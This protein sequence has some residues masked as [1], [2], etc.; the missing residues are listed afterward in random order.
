MHSR[1]A[2]TIVKVLTGIATSP[3][4]AVL[5]PRVSGQRRDLWKIP[6]LFGDVRVKS[7]LL[8]LGFQFSPQP[9]QTQRCDLEICQNSRDIPWKIF[10]GCW[11]SCHL[12]CLNVINV[13]PI[14]RK[15]VEDAL[16]SLSSTANNSLK[17]QVNADL[18]D[19]V[20]YSR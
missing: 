19:V 14:C 9:D 12:C 17:A 6:A 4:S 7:G 8:S 16:R 15:G 10:E 18:L 11:Y 13:C 2:E 5:L 3:Q 20:D 1:V